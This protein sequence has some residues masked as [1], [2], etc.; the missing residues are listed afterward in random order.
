MGTDESSLLFYSFLD[1][2]GG[3]TL[4]FLSKNKQTPSLDPAAPKKK[5]RRP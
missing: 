4:P 2:R 1:N 3:S 5:A